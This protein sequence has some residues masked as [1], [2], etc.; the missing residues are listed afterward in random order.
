M[1]RAQQ[2]RQAV[3][4]ESSPDDVDA[5]RQQFPILSRTMRGQPLVYLDSASTTQKPRRVIDAETRFYETQNANIHRGV[6]E[7]SEEATRAYVAAHE[8]VARF[9]N[10]ASAE[11]I[12]FTRNATEAI[13][14]V[15]HSLADSRLLTPDSRLILTAMEHHSN[16]VPWQEVAQRVGAQLQWV[17]LTA[18]GNLDLEN[19]A[20][21]LSA[22]KHRVFAGRPTPGVCLVA[23]THVS[24]VLG[25]VNPI[26]DIVRMAHEV[27]ALVLVDA[28]QS[29]ARL[30]IDIRAW[31]ADFVAFSG[32]KMYGPTGVGVLYAKRELLEMLPPYIRGGDMVKTVTRAGATWND[33]PWK[34]EAGTPNIAGGVAFGE[35]V[36]FLQETGL[37]NVWKREQEL[38]AYTLP[39]L[40]EIPGLRVVGPVP[41]PNTQTPKRA[42]VFSFTLDGIHSHDLASF[43]DEQ[44]IAIRGG[45][46]CAQPLLQSL[47]L[48]ECARASVGVYTTA[49]DIDRLIGAL[50]QA[51]RILG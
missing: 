48:A 28:A 38:V 39:K 4:R 37:P 19:F 5:I 8:A 47:G 41:R 26:G 13:N 2:I 15:A 50:K 24:N 10:A 34:F 1:K 7:L 45:H 40:L 51:R 22:G 49:E 44:G 36:R 6:Y 17:E 35:A 18:D 43:L 27:G 11:E 12:V 3:V 46:H 21:T 30:P 20:R 16:I 9:V 33:L 32:H 23:V 25:A 31:D 29:V 42:G 14:L